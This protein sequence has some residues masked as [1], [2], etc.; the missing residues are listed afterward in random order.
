LK[1]YDHM[2][3]KVTLKG[4]ISVSLLGIV[5]LYMFSFIDDHQKKEHI[6]KESEYHKE[7]LLNEQKWTNY[8][9]DAGCHPTELAARIYAHEATPGLSEKKMGWKKYESYNAV[10]GEKY[11]GFDLYRFPVRRYGH[12]WRYVYFSPAYVKPD[13]K[14]WY[15]LLEYGVPKRWGGGGSGILEKAPIEIYCSNESCKEYN[16]EGYLNLSQRFE[17]WQHSAVEDAIMDFSHKDMTHDLWLFDFDCERNQQNG[18][19]NP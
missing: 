4:F 11:I 6:K 12:F 9:I 10:G 15:E 13:Q 18:D 8:M 17:H 2:S 1:K 5:L 19:D 3:Q 14:K 7:L 16:I